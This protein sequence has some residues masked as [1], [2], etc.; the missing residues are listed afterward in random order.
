MQSPL[1]MFI[2]ITLASYF[3][4]TTDIFILPATLFL[5][6]MIFQN[7]QN[8]KLYLGFSLLF[9][10]GIFAGHIESIVQIGIFS[11]LSPF[12]ISIEKMNVQKKEKGIIFLKYLAFHYW[13]WD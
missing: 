4:N 2:T 7:K 6:E 13:V 5:I 11:T 10:L 1:C 12:R 8:T 9:A 3:G